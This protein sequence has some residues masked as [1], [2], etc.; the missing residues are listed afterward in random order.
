MKIWYD[1]PAAE[2]D[3]LDQNT[4]ML[5]IGNGFMA[6]MI[7]GQLA[8]ERIQFNEET[9]WTGGPGGCDGYANHEAGGGTG[10]Q[11]NVYRYGHKDGDQAR[12][13]LDVLLEA[14]KDGTFEASMMDE[15]LGTDVGYGS[16]QNFGYLHLEH[17][18]DGGQDVTCYHRE[19]DLETGVA[20]VRY[21]VGEV[22]FS[23]E[24]FASY[25]AKV[26]VIRLSASEANKVNV[27]ASI[28]SSQLDADVNYAYQIQNGIGLMGMDGALTDNSMK[29]SAQFF[30]TQEGGII[31][32]VGEKLKIEQASSVTLVFA[33]ATNYFHDF[34]IE[35][36]ATYRTSELPDGLVYE[37]GKAGIEKGF[38][39]LYRDHIADYCDLFERMKLN[40]TETIPNIPTD[41]LLL[42]YGKGSPSHDRF[43]EMVLFQYGRYLLI[44]SSRVGTLPANLQGKWNVENQPPWSADYHYNINL[45]MNYWLAGNTNLVECTCPLI[46]FIG[47]LVP[48]GNVTARKYFNIDQ[49]WTL[50]TSGNI[51]GLT[52]PG[53]GIGWGWSPANN[54]FI[55]QNL[56]DYYQFSGDLSTLRA[57]VYPT[58]KSAALFWS[59]ALREDGDLLV[60][61]PSLSPEQGPVTYA[62]AYDQQ[63]VWELFDFTIKAIDVLEIEEDFEFKSKLL[64]QMAKLQPVQIGAFGQIMEWR[65]EP[66]DY[67]DQ[68]DKEHR[69]ISQLVGLYPG[70]VINREDV[71]LIEAAKTTLKRRGDAAT[72]WSMGWKIN[73]W[74]RVLDGNHAH[75]LIQNL[76]RENVAVNLFGLHAVGETDSIFQIDANFGY[77]AGVAEMLLQ[78]HMGTLDILPALPDV[79][80]EGEVRGIRARGGYEVDMKWQ[81]DA[82]E[83]SVKTGRDVAEKLTVRCPKFESKVVVIETKSDVELDQKQ[84][85]DK[86]SLFV[87]PESE[88]LFFTS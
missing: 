6:A 48:S 71:A 57:E 49:G 33:A 80:K 28:E 7:S 42:E 64:L 21:K 37:R 65:D 13:S 15:M 29:F 76:I 51:F 63:L 68:Y 50:H 70:T 88:Y 23:R 84:S 20:R 2:S 81:C 79:W 16:Y 25:P 40:L 53:W 83:I 60:V 27:A 43:L 73:F 85:G 32:Q 12:P 31:Q 66:T 18:L 11:G 82:I 54:A 4:A 39:Q 58:I 19:L 35:E 38:D 24:Y 46:E 78:S 1:E 5:P 56:W 61:V 34:S 10:K 22:E 45:Q 26:I 17:D 47:K 69:H 3:I 67:D 74:A 75:Q 86:I 30:V 14:M 55:C 41:Q 87:Q 9:L 62:T 72:G 44:A 52:A 36:T 8:K 59:E 77:T